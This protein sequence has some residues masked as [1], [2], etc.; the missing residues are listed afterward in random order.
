MTYYFRHT[1]QNNQRRKYWVI[2]FFEN[3][4]PMKLRFESKSFKSFYYWLGKQGLHWTSINV[5]ERLPNSGSGDF[6]V[7]LTSNNYWT[8]IKYL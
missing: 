2:V 1:Q 6:I 4:S 8:E 3:R 7:Q 5:Y